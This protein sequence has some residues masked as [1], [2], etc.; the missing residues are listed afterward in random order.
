MTD[1]TTPSENPSLQESVRT[2]SCLCGSVK[3]QLT[4]EP[5]SALNC[6]C[7][8]CK[9]TS[10]AAFL[11]NG[12]FWKKQLT[13]TSSSS[14]LK[15]FQDKTTNSGEPLCRKFC[16]NCGSTLFV[17]SLLPD[18]PVAVTLGSL[19]QG[20]RPWKPR[21]EVFTKDAVDWMPRIEGARV[22]EE[23][24]DPHAFFE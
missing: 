24:A 14:G 5:I 7:V 3:Y 19:D 23:M 15:T 4:G 8:N 10:G 13:I 11:S 20:Q 16:S 17:E 1:Q 6:H 9:K 2:G 22:F 12:L 21:L 18:T